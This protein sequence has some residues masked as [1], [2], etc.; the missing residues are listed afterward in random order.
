MK[1]LFNHTKRPLPE[2][3]ENDDFQYEWDQEDSLEADGSGEAGVTE[4]YGEEAYTGES[5]D[6]EAYA[7]EPYGEEAYADE[8]YIEETGGE[9]AYAGA[10]KAVL[11]GLLKAEKFNYGGVYGGVEA[12]SALVR[13]DGGVELDPVAPVDPNLS[14]V[15]NPGH[16]KLDKALR[17]GNALHDAPFFVLRVS[18]DNGFK[19]GKDLF[20]RLEKFL[21]PG[22][23]PFNAF[24]HS[25][26]IL[27]FE[28]HKKSPNFEF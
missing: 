21:F 14:A 4:D 20:H 7:D 15:V 8:S 1:K 22:V 26:K 9:A 16:A 27:T 18:F 6:E 19:G 17:L 12:D 25:F 5:Y 10:G 24:V 28:C 23:P 3:D 2:W 13:T 11:K